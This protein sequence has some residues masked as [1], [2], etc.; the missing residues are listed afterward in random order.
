MADTTLPILVAPLSVPALAEQH[1][2]D[3]DSD[4]GTSAIQF[5]RETMGDSESPLAAAAERCKRV[6]SRAAEPHLFPDHE[7]LLN[8]VIRPLREAKLCFVLDMPIACIAQSGLVAE[9]VAIWRHRMLAPTLKPESLAESDR[10]A[11][12]AEGF[13][14]LDQ[15]KRI[16]FLK[17]YDSLNDECRNAFGQLKAIRRTYM[18]Y[19]TACID[20]Q[21]RDAATAYQCACT[22]VNNAL[23]LTID[24]GRAVLPPRALLFFQDLVQIEC[25]TSD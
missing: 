13:D 18:H 25:N 7:I 8:N 4:N 2:V 19:M 10:K 11:F 1:R 24:N 17:K 15:S 22:L 16:D 12:A 6:E 23:D 5:L 9:M 21:D 3:A 20:G 14:Q